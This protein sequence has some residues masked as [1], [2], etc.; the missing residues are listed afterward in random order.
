M[1]SFSVRRKGFASVTK[2]GTV[3]LRLAGDDIAA[4]G[5]AHP[6]GSPILRDGT[7]TGFG[8]PLADVN[9]QQLNWLVRRAWFHRAPKRLAAQIAAADSGVAPE[10]N[11]LPKAIGRPAT[12]ALLT[13]GL[14]TLD[15]VATRTAKELLALH[16]MGPKAVRIL[17]EALTERGS[18]LR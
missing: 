14:T 10:G 11:D 2:D 18:A 16:G 3:Q 13:A 6:T 15:Q 9:G 7:P 8:V 4:A 5:S 12:Q 1:V 17:S